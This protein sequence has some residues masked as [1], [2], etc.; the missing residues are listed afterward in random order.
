MLG[1]RILAV[2]CCVVMFFAGTPAAYAKNVENE[3]Y[4]EAYKEYQEKKAA[5]QEIY[6]LVDENGNLWGYFEKDAN[7]SFM[8]YGSNI[9]WTIN[10]N[11]RKYGVNQ[12]TLSAGAQIHVNITQSRTGTSYLCFYNHST[13]SYVKFTKTKTSNGWVGKIVVLGS[14]VSSGVYSFG[15]QNSSSNTI[16]YSGTYSL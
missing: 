5:G 15:I 4:L 10:S 13:G 6:D 14:G 2:V 11:Y 1:K 16:R 12:Y 3:A 9:D 7:A 8:R